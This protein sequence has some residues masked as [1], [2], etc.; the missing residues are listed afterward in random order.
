MLADAR[1]PAVLA[2]AG[3]AVML[4]LSPSPL[5]CAQPLPLPPP[6]TPDC[7]FPLP[8]PP[9]C[10]LLLLRHALVIPRLAALAALA[11][12]LSVL[13]PAPPS[14]S[15]T[16]LAPAPA[17]ASSIASRAPR[18]RQVRPLPYPRV[19]RPCR[20]GHT[21]R[22]RLRTLRAPCPPAALERA[23][24]VEG[25]AGALRAAED[26]SAAEGLAAHG[27]RAGAGRGRRGGAVESGG[28][29]GE[30][31]HGENGDRQRPARYARER[32]SISSGASARE[33]LRHVTHLL[34][35]R[36]TTARAAEANLAATMRASMQARAL[37][38]H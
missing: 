21:R 38:G 25:A 26:R 36:Y 23:G 15:A 7:R 24:R 11:P 30:S 27:T 31:V 4:A 14:P 37:R 10:L 32:I 5:R 33:G 19:P 9:L 22:C 12:L 2:P 6:L 29:E 1:A 17:P 20:P 35:L 18:P 8:C 16:S 3:F 13:A 28:L 34:P